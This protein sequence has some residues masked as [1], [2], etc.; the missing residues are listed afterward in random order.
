MRQAQRYPDELCRS[1]CEGI[2]MQKIMDS[3]GLSSIFHMC[4]DSSCQAL[5]DEDHDIDYDE[6]Y[7]VDDV[8]GRALDITEVR[9]VRRE[10][11]EHFRKHNVYK[12][13]PLALCYQFTGKAPIKTRWIDIN[14]GD[15]A[16]PNYRS[17]LVAKEF[18]H[19]RTPAPDMFVATPPLEARNII[20]S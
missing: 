5:S 2:I 1:V 7:A 15:A 4:A 20:M 8:S 9:K 18:R 10:E 11:M 6:E 16:C 13:V 12:K 3:T 19:T 14:K 17:R